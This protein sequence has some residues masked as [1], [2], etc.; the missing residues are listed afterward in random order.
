MMK[1][2]LLLVLLCFK[3]DVIL[4]YSNKNNENGTALD[5]KMF[6]KLS[7]QLSENNSSALL[8]LQ[9]KL[10]FLAD[11]AGKKRLWII[12]APDEA[13]HY[14]KM[15]EK[16]IKEAQGTLLNC[17]LAERDVYI[18]TIFH[19]AV[20]EGKLQ[21]ISKDGIMVQEAINQD[22]IPQL[23]NVLLLEYGK[24]EMI[25]MKKNLQVSERFPYPV[26]TEAVLET[27]DQFPLR[28]IEKVARRRFLQKC[29][30]P[31][32][33]HRAESRKKKYYKSKHTQS[34]P[35]TIS[36]LINQKSETQKDEIKQKVWQILNE[37]FP[38]QTTAV[39]VRVPS[40]LLTVSAKQIPDVDH[41]TV[42]NVQLL[43]DSQISAPTAE[44]V[45]NLGR[46]MSHNMDS[47]TSVSFPEMT[48]ES[49]L[50]TES[51]FS[52]LD[53]LDSK[54]SFHTDYIAHGENP[55]TDIQ[56]KD[57]SYE[58]SA[59]AKEKRNKRKHKN[60][61]KRANKHG[62]R[63]RRQHQWEWSTQV[64]AFL[65]HF[66]YI[67]RLLI[68]SVLDAGNAYYIH[69]RDECLQHF[70]ELALRNI[71]V[72][73]LLGSDKNG[74][75]MLDSEAPFATVILKSIDSN[76]VAELRQR[77]GISQEN[78]L[79]TLTDFDLRPK[80]YFDRPASIQDLMRTFDAFP[81][82]EPDALQNK[83]YT[84]TFQT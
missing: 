51:I 24:F 22:I 67:R 68:I 83:K 61:N 65:N 25:V 14:Y 70:Q 45:L 69:Q 44:L 84:I 19:G 3:G 78:F 10:D 26:R 47:I 63:V 16:H 41:V 2:C 4:S 6:P 48:T 58:V 76:L 11:F 52:G 17:Q 56:A 29:K 5:L 62:K 13:N 33:R 49:S 40:D 64:L 34:V 23:M 30:K 60:D 81:S 21:K 57:V 27:I 55:S 39:T 32:K 20:M 8:A 15:M 28:K 7:P 50:R 36:V 9:M 31:G 72:I 82:R 66:R 43:T 80:K 59:K 74:T 73:T 54:I 12:A 46:Y 38:L 75:V 71:S 35:K 42:H 37:R 1:G 79:I 77:F 53:S 18:L